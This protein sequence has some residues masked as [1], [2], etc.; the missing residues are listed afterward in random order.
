MSQRISG[1]ATL[2]QLGKEKVGFQ[3]PPRST[4][5]E[6]RIP[7]LLVRSSQLRIHASR[8]QLR[9]P[10]SIDID[11]CCSKEIRLFTLGAGPKGAP[12]HPDQGPLGLRLYFWLSTKTQMLATPPLSCLR[13]RVAAS[14]TTSA[15]SLH[16]GVA[17]LEPAV[18]RQCT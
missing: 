1:K 8:Q 6:T 9:N 10:R 4:R 5:A 11:H 14:W 12:G 3:L 7:H 16:S 17:S 2:P 18:G 15:K 13:A